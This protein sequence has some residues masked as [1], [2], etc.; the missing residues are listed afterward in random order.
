MQLQTKP[1]LPNWSELG[2]NIRLLAPG[3]LLSVTVAAAASFLSAHYGAPQMLFAL[4]LGIA[5]HF[6]AEDGKCQPV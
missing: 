1:R 2:K 4:L 3:L 6:L 5:F